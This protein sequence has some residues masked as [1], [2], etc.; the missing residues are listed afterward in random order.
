VRERETSAEWSGWDG[1]GHE[2]LT[3]G[4]ESGGWTADGVVSGTVAH[5]G[6]HYVVRVDQD[7]HLRQFLLF[8][9][10]PEPDLWLGVDPAGRWGEMNGAHRPELDGCTDVDLSCTPFTNTLP[11]R[12]LQFLA[13][14]DA[15]E[16]V[17]ARVDHET[18]GIV[19]ERQRYT[20][21][22]ALRWRYEDESGFTAELEV[23]ADGLVLDYPGLFRRLL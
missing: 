20:R 15:V 12:R 4:W 19:P 11:I 18:L 5:S 17:V 9:D 6:I 16:L 1:A 14:G 13:E 10:D 21:L 3:V 2:V 7:W 23:D 22:G 8:R